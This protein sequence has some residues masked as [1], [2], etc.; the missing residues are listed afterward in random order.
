MSTLPRRAVSGEIGEL[1][2]HCLELRQKSHSTL[3]RWIEC[4]A[5]LGRFR[6]SE[7]PCTARA[8]NRFP[9]R[10]PSTRAAERG[11]LA[12]RGGLASSAPVHSDLL[13]GKPRSCRS[14]ATNSTP[15]FDYDCA[16]SVAPTTSFCLSLTV[17]TVLSGRN[18]NSDDT[19]GPNVIIGNVLHTTSEH[20]NFGGL[21]DATRTS[22]RL[23]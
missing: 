17:E 11:G 9:R 23:R 22:H 3:C 5:S 16:P 21:S 1:W 13:R 2:A 14:S 15:S 10:R 12:R 18:E 8:Y 6:P 20:G 19:G 4:R 7:A